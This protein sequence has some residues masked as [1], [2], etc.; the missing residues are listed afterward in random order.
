MEA[1]FK[2]LSAAIDV[3]FDRF[4]LE[5]MK[6]SGGSV[7]AGDTSDVAIDPK[8]G[9]ILAAATA[10]RLVIAA[11]MSA[12]AAFAGAV[13]EHARWFTGC[14]CHDYI[15]MKPRVSDQKKQRTHPFLRKS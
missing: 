7:P 6:T 9:R 1:A 4:N 2:R 5:Q 11:T 8:A 12:H 13:G 15:W 14:V 10:D 3:F